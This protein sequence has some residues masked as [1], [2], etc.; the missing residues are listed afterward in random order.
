MASV[1]MEEAVLRSNAGALAVRVAA[2]EHVRG[3]CGVTA[4]AS[5]EVEVS[6][7]AMTVQGIRVVRAPGGGL[8]CLPPAFR[9]PDGRWLPSVTVS[10]E[11]SDT[12]SAAVLKAMP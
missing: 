2:I 8:C 9:H 6:G 12:I 1:I 7:L 5:V 3:S 11:L 4:L 10:A